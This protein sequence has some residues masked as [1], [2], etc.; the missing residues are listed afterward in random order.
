MFRFCFS[1]RYRENRQLKG[2]HLSKRV[3]RKDLI[4]ASYSLACL[5]FL[6]IF[7]YVCHIRSEWSNSNTGPWGLGFPMPGNVNSQQTLTGSESN[8]NN[9]AGF[10]HGLPSENEDSGDFQNDH[11]CSL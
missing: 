8:S 9:F 7:L 11:L 10:F 1:F 6:M 2:I 3:R 4:C 5:T